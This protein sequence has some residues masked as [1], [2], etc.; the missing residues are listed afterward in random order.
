[1]ASPELNRIIR[2]TV[3]QKAFDRIKNMI[4]TQELK[5]GQRI[6]HDALALE[7]NIS[8]TPVKKALTKLAELGLITN[9][10]K[11]YTFVRQFTKNEII[12]MYDV[13]EMLEGLS[14]KLVAETAQGEDIEGLKKIFRSFSIP[15]KQPLW[16]KYSEADLKF[17]ES[18]AQRSNNPILR[19]IF[20]RFLL[21]ITTIRTF[22]IRSPDVSLKEHLEI[23][24]AI[25]DHNP[26][27]AE[28]LIRSH[29]RMTRNE[30]MK[31]IDIDVS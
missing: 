7:L 29:I 1:M 22:L 6:V 5:P 12:A 25:E 2:D 27:L 26:D 23:I 21:Q 10:E 17:H 14:A 30:I 8:R 31:S 11:G 20:Q 13:R 19:E 15:I 16:K 28:K 9:T 4:V 24:G 18:L 3:E